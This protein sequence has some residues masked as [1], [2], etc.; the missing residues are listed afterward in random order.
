MLLT[1]L[2][3]SINKYRYVFSGAFLLKFSQARILFGGKLV[4][5]VA[6]TV[7]QPLRIKY[8]RGFWTKIERIL[9]CFKFLKTDF[10]G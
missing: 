8:L 5:G 7:D 3:C 9:F 1:Q 10:S 2:F 4:A 6:D